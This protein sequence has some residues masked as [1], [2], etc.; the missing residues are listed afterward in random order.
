MVNI[1]I[2]FHNNSNDMKMITEYLGTHELDLEEYDSSAN[3]SEGYMVT[4]IRE[5]FNGYCVKGLNMWREF[6]MQEK[7]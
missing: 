2:K 6:L 1:N 4:S 5:R 7:Y 3:E